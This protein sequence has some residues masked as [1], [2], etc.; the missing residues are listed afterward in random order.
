MKYIADSVRDVMLR[1]WTVPI[2]VP[3]RGEGGVMA[4]VGKR[5]VYIPLPRRKV[6]W[7]LKTKSM[8]WKGGIVRLVV[9][10]W[11]VKGAKNGR[12]LVDRRK[13]AG[14]VDLCDECRFRR[15]DQYIFTYMQ[16]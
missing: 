15:I 7:R 1:A 5:S 2:G 13:A 9:G 10:W 16:S 8:G 3:C 14:V 4:E 11:Y 12:C 6:A